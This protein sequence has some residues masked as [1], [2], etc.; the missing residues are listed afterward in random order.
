MAISN[1]ISILSAFGCPSE[2]VRG[3]QGRQDSIISTTYVKCACVKKLENQAKGP[4]M[5]KN[6]A[7]RGKIHE[8]EDSTQCPACLIHEARE[9]QQ[10]ELAAQKERADY[11]ARPRYKFQIK[12]DCEFYIEGEKGTI[13]TPAEMTCDAFVADELQNIFDWRILGSSLISS[14]LKEFDA[15]RKDGFQSFSYPP[16]SWKHKTR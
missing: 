6:K 9:A 4:E 12:L 14:G 10:K 2:G 3:R 16:K 11:A 1:N 13:L 7:K 15:T 8:C 5:K